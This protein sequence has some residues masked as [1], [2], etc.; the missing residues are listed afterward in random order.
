MVDGR[1]TDQVFFLLAANKMFQKRKGKFWTFKDRASDD[2]RQLDYILVR[3][4]WRNSVHNAEACN[5]FNTVNSYHRIVAAKL[6][7]S[8]RAPRK[9]KTI[10]YNWKLFSH[11]MEILLL[12]LSDPAALAQRLN[13]IL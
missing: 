3:K 2:L 10:S 9:E 5:F 8:L 6:K 4:K 13:D 1:N 7:L 11:T 12:L